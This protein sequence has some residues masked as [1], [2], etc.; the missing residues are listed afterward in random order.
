MKILTGLLAILGVVGSVL[1]FDV[2]QIQA[3]MVAFPAGNLMVALQ[4]LCN[5]VGVT[6]G[7]L[8]LHFKFSLLGLTVDTDQK[9][10]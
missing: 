3:A 7:A 1:I 4:D 6:A 5:V 10:N 8:H 2:T 9:P